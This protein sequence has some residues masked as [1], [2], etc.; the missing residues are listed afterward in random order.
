MTGSTASS[1]AI[2]TDNND[3]DNIGRVKVKF[4][5]LGDDV[6][7]WWARIAAPG[8]GPDYG[9]VWVPQV[10]DEVLVGFL[11]GDVR[12]PV[13][14]RAGCG[15]AWTRSRSTPAPTSTPAR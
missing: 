7:S 3:P 11:H 4:P 14:A 9:I 10:N 6:E 5:W 13:R 15:T 1:S 8:A 2:V 12:M